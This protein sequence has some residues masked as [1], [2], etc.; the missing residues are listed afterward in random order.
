M[1]VKDNIVLMAWGW[2]WCV[3]MDFEV[4][5]VWLLSVCL[6]S[7]RCLLER[8]FYM[9]IFMWARDASLTAT[10]CLRSPSSHALIG[11]RDL[12]IRHPKHYYPTNGP[13]NKRAYTS[14]YHPA[15]HILSKDQHWK[16]T[17]A[18]IHQIWTPR[19]CKQFSFIVI[20]TSFTNTINQT[21]RNN[22]S[23]K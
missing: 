3:M 15:A 7:Q 18:R 6:S 4:A 19:F 20:I 8:A 2:V 21:C 5:A 1:Y 12:L 23:P 9:A 22:V 17:H 16:Q 10:N 14:A 11:G 13:S